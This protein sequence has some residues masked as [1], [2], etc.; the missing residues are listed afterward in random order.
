MHVFVV[1]ICSGNLVASVAMATQHGGIVLD[2]SLLRCYT[3]LDVVFANRALVSGSLCHPML[4]G[5]CNRR[6]E[7]MEFL[8]VCH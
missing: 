5:H 3:C 4:L 1:L 6:S 2:Y 7:L 8:I